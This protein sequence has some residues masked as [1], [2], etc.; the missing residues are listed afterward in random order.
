VT[1]GRHVSLTIQY[2]TVAMTEILYYTV[3]YYTVRLTIL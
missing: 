2:S 1:V 3:L